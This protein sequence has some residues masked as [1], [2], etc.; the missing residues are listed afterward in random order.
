MSDLPLDDVHRLLDVIERGI[1]ELDDLDGQTIDV[2]DIPEICAAVIELN[3]WQ[4]TAYNGNPLGLE[5]AVL[6]KFV[7]MRGQVSRQTARVV[8]G[9]VRS[10]LRSQD[11]LTDSQDPVDEA[12]DIEV[13]DAQAG[14]PPA[15][16][17]TDN[18]Q[19]LS[20]AVTAERWVPVPMGSDIRRKIEMIASLLD[21]I[22]A[23]VERSNAPPD[24]QALT[25]LEKAQLIAILETTLAILKAPL[26]EKGMLKK[27]GDALGRAAGKA[28]EKGMQEGMGTLA[29]VARQKIIE[30]LGLFF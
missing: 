19:A 14:S 25:P 15:D 11:Q 26:V 24:E 23:Q 4:Q 9:R 10:Y 28:A 8:A 27:A 1:A 6:S 22:V 16:A 7:K 30:L 18:G 5:P 3:D 21:S 29:G 2:E 20:L 13:D 17:P 12:D